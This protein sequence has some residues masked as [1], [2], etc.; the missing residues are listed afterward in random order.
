MID[1][2]LTRATPTWMNREDDYSDIVISTRIRLARN[3]DGYR[4]P[5][6]FSE[7]EALQIEQAVTHAIKDSTQLSQNYAY[8]AIKDLSPLQR[9]ILVEKHLISPQLAKKEQVGSMLLSE[10][11]AVSIMVNEE[12]HLRI[13]CM[14]ASFQLQQAYEQADAI[15]RILEKTLPYAFRGTF[16][17]LTSCP[18]N[19]GTGL[20]ASVMMHLP[21]LTLTGQMNQ[22]IN[23]MTRLGMTVRGIYGE[24]S[25]SLANMY[26][27][28][29]QITLGKA[30]DDILA[31]IQSVAEKIIQKERQAR[32]RLLEKAEFALEDRVYRALGTLTHARILTSEEAATCLSNVRL[33]IDLKLIDNIPATTINEC[34]VSMQPGFLQHYVNEILPPAER[35]RI[36]ATMLR[37]VLMNK[38][39]IDEKG[40]D[41][42]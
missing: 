39:M 19:I 22:I 26:Q 4:F 27:V 30:E 3:L 11:E 32:E 1:S 28:S 31:D 7:N 41:A 6:A 35:D 29:N 18:T 16:G 42:I 9:Q 10:D 36:R 20:R 13:Q 33:G 2:F 12:D 15:D 17:Y 23:A 25:E 14:T 40:A 34:I 38:P 24:G 8:F 5:L 37:E 21:A